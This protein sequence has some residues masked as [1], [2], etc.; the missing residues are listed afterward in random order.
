MVR[1]PSATRN[2]WSRLEG[3]LKKAEAM[4]SKLIAIVGV[5]LLLSASCSLA[6][7]SILN[8]IESLE[9]RLASSEVAAASARQQLVSM[10]ARVEIVADGLKPVHSKCESLEMQL[11][12]V[13]SNLGE[14]SSATETLRDDQSG[15]ADAL[16]TTAIEIGELQDSLTRALTEAR[17]E[18]GQVRQVLDTRAQKSADL[19]RLVT[20][21]S[22][23][24]DATTVQ[25][26]GLPFGSIVPWL[27]G[28]EPLPQGWAICDG[29]SGTPDLRDTFLRGASK[30]G[31]AGAYVDASEMEPA[32]FHTHA[33]KSDRNMYNLA[34]A[35][36]RNA[37]DWLMLFD[38]GSNVPAA[39]AR[40]NHGEHTHLDENIPAHFTVVFIV[41]VAA[42][43]NQGR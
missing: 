7:L 13:L 8:E 5:G 26:A 36:P 17:D 41:K 28:S 38:A 15:Q 9:G 11:S 6:L 16:A 42:A 34:R 43:P 37:G 1:I 2:C 14:V 25:L 31:N 33:T 21:L 32:G 27:P 22:E 18:V 39:G 29:R 40:A 30:S 10:E 35:T 24:V 19:E 20:G 3:P 23:K 4:S 12:T